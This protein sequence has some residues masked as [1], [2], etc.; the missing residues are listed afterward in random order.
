MLPSFTAPWELA[1]GLGVLVVGVFF[2][3]TLQR[4]LCRCA[5][6][7]R[8]MTPAL[9]WLDLVPLFGLVW[10]FV[11]V[12][13]VA[14][15]LGSELR[16]RGDATSSGPVLIL[17]LAFAFTGAA[18]IGSVV[19]YYGGFSLILGSGL[20]GG[21]PPEGSFYSILALAA[22]ALPLL[23]LASLLWVVY[24]L[25]IC[26]YS[27]RLNRP[28]SSPQSLQ[29]TPLAGAFCPWCGRQIPQTAYCPACGTPQR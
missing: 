16:S 27:R 1:A 2:V 12:V 5:Q 7:N 3:L 23:V 11:V 21:N 14:K 25:L 26:G 18:S 6:H 8:A 20:A 28:N 17:G 9:V 29:A 13:K 15:S 10:N 22:I 4:V 19:G 24:W